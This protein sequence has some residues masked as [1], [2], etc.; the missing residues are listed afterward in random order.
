MILEEP[1]LDDIID[2]KNKLI[3]SLRFVIDYFE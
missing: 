1:L 3:K 2:N